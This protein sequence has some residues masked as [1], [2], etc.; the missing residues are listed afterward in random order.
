MQKVILVTGVSSGFG[1]NIAAL[2][3]K[4][5]HVVY[6][7][8]RK[9]IENIGDF[10]QVIMDVTDTQSVTSAIS[11]ILTKEGRIDVVI[12][13]AGMGIGGP[14]EDFSEE[15]ALLQ[16][17]TN[18]MG[19]FRVCKAVLP[20]MRSRKNGL[21]INISSVGGLMGLPFQGFYSASKYA[22]EGFSE[23]L[24]YETK[25]FNIKVVLVNPGDFSTGFTANRKPVQ[26]MTS[27][28]AYFSQYS[29]TLTIIE[30]DE[31]NGMN[32]IVLAKKINRIVNNKN[33]KTRYVIASFEQKLAVW[34]KYIL[35]EKVFFPLI[36]GHYGL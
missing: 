2:L 14:V 32:P 4:A 15:D 6:G 20:S 18:F 25:Q 11:G 27:Q 1:R 26:N 28:S 7:T 13:N 36:G 34:L 33:P 3:H 30:N 21:I 29:K 19:V 23:S 31:N 12:N 5:G 24:R 35:P 17:N 8:C 10:N 22:L 16:M 9:P